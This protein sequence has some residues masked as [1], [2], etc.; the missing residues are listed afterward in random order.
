VPSDPE[1]RHG[2]VRGLGLCRPDDAAAALWDSVTALDPSAADLD[3]GRSMR[4]CTPCELQALW[5]AAGLK[6]VRISAVVVTAGYEGFE[7]L[8]EP[9]ESGVAPSGAYVASLPPDRR[10]ALKADFQHRLGAGTEPFRLGARA[11]LAMGLVP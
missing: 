6:Q 2:R 7:D 1:R 5:T 10:A 9:L 4:Y 3:E 11:W 8:W